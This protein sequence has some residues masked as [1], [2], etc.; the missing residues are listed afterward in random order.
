MRV[1]TVRLL[2]GAWLVAVALSDLAPSSVRAQGLVGGVQPMGRTNSVDGFG[3]DAQLIGGLGFGLDGKLNNYF[4]A[5]GRLGLLYATAPWIVNLGLTVD[6]GALAGLGWGGEL[7]LS[8]GGSLFGTVGVSRVDHDRWLMHAGLGFMIFGLEYQHTFD[9]PKPNNA[10]LVEVRLPLGLWWLQKRQEKADAKGAT[11]VRTPQ[12]KPRVGQPVLRQ[13]TRADDDDLAARS[14][15]APRSAAASSDAGAG[16]GA[17][18]AGAAPAAAPSGAAPS[19]GGRSSSAAQSGG[20]A[21][22]AQGGSGGRPRSVDAATVEAEY[23]TR[24]AEASAARDRGDRL[25][26]AF[27]LSRAYALRPEPVVALQLAAA[28][29]ALGR[30]RSARATWQRVGDV[31]QLPEAERERANQLQRELAAALSHVRLELQGAPPEQ[32]TVLIDGV[33]EPLATQGYD[34]PLDPG[35]HKLQLRRDEQVILERDFQ[36][37][38]GALLRLPV[39]VPR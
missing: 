37:Q 33:I 26:E 5:R 20:R 9:G 34:L 30:P 14:G 39:D 12:V 13:P 29:L 4:L 32:L 25:V 8:R 6:V 2:V 22:G 24:L 16:Q 23:A 10:L 38:A 19:E 28:E 7:E 3:P 1:R 27:A 36:T 35:T 15:E 11:A 18:G 21:A 17:S 31:E